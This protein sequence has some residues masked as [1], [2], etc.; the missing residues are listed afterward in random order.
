MPFACS[1]G[2]WAAQTRVLRVTVAAPTALPRGKGNFYS[3]HST[4]LS[5]LFDQT[6]IKLLY[7]RLRTYPSGRRTTPAFVQLARLS[8]EE[9]TLTWSLT[10]ARQFAH[11]CGCVT[12][13]RPHQESS[14]IWILNSWVA[15]QKKGPS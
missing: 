3:I 11:C 1:L 13:R 15:V 2:P 14:S 8:C 10:H 6:H 9:H 4:S 7:G 5:Q 12:L